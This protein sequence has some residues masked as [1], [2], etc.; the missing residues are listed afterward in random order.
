MPEVLIN[1]YCSVADVQAELKNHN[2]AFG[3][4]VAS[5]VITLAI[6]RASRWVDDYKARDYFLHDHSSTVLTITLW[7]AITMENR[8]YLP[9]PNI[10]TLTEVVE[11][12]ITLTLNTDFIYEYDRKRREV[13]ALIRLGGSLV[14]FLT[15]ENMS[16]DPRWMIGEPPSGVVTLKGKFGYDQA[17]SAAVPTGIP[18]EIQWATI[19]VAAAFTGHNRKEVVGVDGTKESIIDRSIPKTVYDLLGRKGPILV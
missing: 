3:S 16:P 18:Q 11:G 10:I 15:S 12:G 2:T 8:L 9:F 1:P 5:D 17:T 6:N 7:D 19:Q 13:I 14:S 4:D